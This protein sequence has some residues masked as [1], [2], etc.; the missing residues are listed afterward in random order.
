MTQSRRQ[1]IFNWLSMV[2]WS[3]EYC[4]K[5]IHCFDICGRCAITATNPTTCTNAFHFGCTVPININENKRMVCDGYHLYA[6]LFDAVKMNAV[7][8]PNCSAFFKK[9]RINCKRK[10]PI[11]LF[12]ACF[13]DFKLIRRGHL[14]MAFTS[15]LRDGRLNCHRK[16]SFTV[17]PRQTTYFMDLFF[18]LCQCIT[19]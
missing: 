19:H 14:H 16:L 17:R 10:N 5:F 18:L 3:F 6:S 4:R 9:F 1:S 11:Q 8:L 13:L 15:S 2:S 7:L 12:D